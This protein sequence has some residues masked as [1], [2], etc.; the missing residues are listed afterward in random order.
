MA[1]RWGLSVGDS[2]T[3][4]AGERGKAHKL[5]VAGIF[6]T[7]MYEYDLH[8]TVSSLATAQELLGQTGVI[9]GVG[10]RLNSAIEAVQVKPVLQ[11]RLGYPYWVTSWMDRN[12][13]LFAAL[14]LEKTAMFLILTLI[15]LVACFNIVATLLTLVVQKTKEIGILKAVGASQRSIRRIFTCAGLTLGTLG[16]GLGVGV[17]LAL[18]W[19]LGKYQFVQLPPEIYYIDHL[20]VLLDLGDALS[21]VVAAL[22]ISW[23][24]CLYPAWLA[25]RL[26]PAGALRYE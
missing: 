1:R 7:G 5:Q 3:V 25:A 16:T 2:L 17:G 14:K 11:K 8:L 21:V 18:C 13:N 9:S 24:A 10:V 23:L 12:K 20:P 4:V 19:A 26:D 6:T 22:G 15:V